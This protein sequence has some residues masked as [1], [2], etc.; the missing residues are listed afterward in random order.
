MKSLRWL[1]WV[2]VLFLWG[3]TRLT[4]DNYNKITMGMDYTAVTALIGTP[5]TCDDVMGMRHCHW[6]DDKSGVDISFAGN[7][8]LLFSAENLQ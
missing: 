5:K 6:G 2:L 1:T 8:V 7:K 4:L 3:C